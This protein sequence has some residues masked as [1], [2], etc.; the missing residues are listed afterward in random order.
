[1]ATALL[2]GAT[3]VAG[4]QGCSD[5]RARP[6]AQDAAAGTRGPGTAGRDPGELPSASLDLPA[7]RLRSL[8]LLDA[9]Q[10]PRQ[11]LRYA[12]G[13]GGVFTI[14]LRVQSR[15]QT[16][17]RQSPWGKLPEI[18][19]GLALERAGAQAPLAVRGLPIE[20]GAIEADDPAV[21]AYVTAAA[22]Q[23]A[24]RHRDQLAGRRAT[25]TID[26][27]GLIRALVPV[28]G[29]APAPGP[30]TRQEMLQILAESVVPLPGAAVGAGARWRAT[31]LMRRG[32]GMV[33]Q[34]ATYELQAVEQGD[35][36]PVWRI[37][38]A[39]AQDGEHQVVS[40]PG[41]PPG[42]SAEL[43]ALVW[44]AEGDLVVSPAAFTP[45]S[46]TLAVEYRVHSR[47]DDGRGKLESYLE[48]KGEV[49]LAT[50]PG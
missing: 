24:Q 22:G 47:L 7:P 43:L 30:H 50:E 25:A 27:R 1:M 15:E 26:D 44:R 39:L 36:G 32:A 48:T 17:D 41:L 34:V 28:A 13:A 29:A 6:A 40:A 11:A 18:R 16:G 5:R 23:L 8:E 35:A 20:V 45:V 31:M 9:G 49:A 14:T 3:L 19:Y 10:E 38:A 21:R 2:A 46:G 37:H 42:V 33:N 4:C 12:A